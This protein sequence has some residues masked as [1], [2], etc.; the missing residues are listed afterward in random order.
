[1]ENLDYEKLLPE[2]PKHDAPL[3]VKPVVRR[4]KKKCCCCLKI[5]LIIFAVF[6]G[7][8]LMGGAFMYFQGRKIVRK[9]TVT[10]PK[11]FPVVDIPQAKLDQVKD[12]A[13]LFVDTIRAGE[14]PEEDFVITA[15][16]INGFF[17]HSDFLRGN[18][19]ISLTEDHNEIKT[20]FSVPTDFL[21]G[22]AG[23]YFVGDE[24]IDIERQAH[25]VTY[26]LDVAAFD[27]IAPGTPLVL[28]V[29]KYTMEN[30]D[31]KHLEVYLQNLKVLGQDKAERFIAKHYNILEDIY[32]DPDNADVT[33]VVAQI[34]SIAI[35]ND[36]IVVKPR[37]GDATEMQ[38]I[39]ETNSELIQEKTMLRNPTTLP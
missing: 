28:A 16:E 38:N 15:E 2:D 21:P 33:Q 6:F 11:H 24:A 39:A 3:E 5:C 30:F 9:I 7:L 17:G 12:R 19:Y 23:R 13:M 26:D 32:N 22:G 18:I 35:E 31:S 1:M 10:T 20:Q 4:P 34:E 14:V 8:L 36:S 37:R 29:F 25:K 27:E